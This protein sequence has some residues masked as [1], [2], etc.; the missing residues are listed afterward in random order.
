MERTEG[1]RELATA[2]AGLKER[3]GLSYKELAR[4]VF[5]SSSTLHRYCSGKGI[6]GEYETVLKIATE[7]KAEPDELNRLL[8]YWKAAKGESPADIAATIDGIQPSRTFARS[9]H[10]HTARLVRRTLIGRWTRRRLVLVVAF[11]V[12]VFGSA[13]ASVPSGGGPHGAETPTRQ[14]LAG[15]ARWVQAPSPVDPTLFGVTM[16]SN[17]GAMPSF[18]VG[19]VRFWDSETRWS[20]LEPTRGEYD[21]STL[22]RLLDEAQGKGLP[23]FFVFGGTPSWA[24]PGARR[25]AYPDGSRAAPPDDLDE[26]DAFVRAL[27]EH[28]GSRIDAYELWVTANHPHHYN[29]TV[30]TLVDM[31]RRA[32]AIIRRHDN[33]AMVICPSVTDLWKAEAHRFLLRFA[34]LGGYQYCDAA[35]IKLYQRRVQDPPETMLEAVERIDHTFHRAGFHPPLWSTG[36]TQSIPLNA[37]LYEE[38]AADYAVRFYLTGLYARKFSLQRMYFYAWGNATIPIVIQAEGG[39]PTK[40]GLYIEHLQRWLA[41]AEIRSC[42]NGLSIDLPENVWQCEF[43]VTD[44]DGRRHTA[45]IRWTITDTAHTVVGSRAQRVEYLDGDSRRVE[46]RDTITITERPV[47]IVDR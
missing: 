35:G 26:W 44:G 40:A 3:S 25:A 18:R 5:T 34:E 32:S 23:T 30:Q 27:V 9:S 43:L 46:A 42:G 28:A 33:D 8:Q 11:I 22:D 20:Q 12:T 45:R 6:P 21:W 19:S 24:A 41:H 7:C 39:P 47:L 36:T 38:R 10:D 4:K 1:A 31:T 37:P 17:S 29:G 15:S 14:T 2:L 13:V 16:N